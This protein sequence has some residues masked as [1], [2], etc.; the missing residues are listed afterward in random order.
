MRLGLFFLRKTYNQNTRRIWFSAVAVAV[1]VLLMLLFLSAMNGISAKERRSAWQLFMIDSAAQQPIADVTPLYITQDST[2]NG[3]NIW[4]NQ[5][6]ATYSLYASSPSSPNLPGLETPAAGTYYASPQL[7]KLIQQDTTGLLNA[8]LGGV[9]LGAIPDPLLTS[10]EQLLVIRGLSADEMQKANE[11]SRLSSLYSIPKDTQ[12]FSRL[13]WGLII[14]GIIGLLIPV[15]MFISAATRFGSV[16]KN[17]RYAALRLVGATRQQIIGI[18]S[19]ETLFVVL[20][21]VTIGWLLYLTCRPILA[22][23]RLSGSRFFIEDMRVNGEQILFVAAAT[24][25]A[26]IIA[27][28]KAMRSVQNSPLGV[29][30]VLKIDRSPSILSIIPL[31]VGFALL[32]YTVIRFPSHFIDGTQDSILV[33]MLMAAFI[34]ISSGILLS[35]PLLTKTVASLAARIS[36]RPEAI[37]A[38]KRI[39]LYPH[40]SFM[41]V[42]GVI[43]ALFLGSYYFALIS[44]TDKLTAVQINTNSYWLLRDDVLMIQR[45]MSPPN[46][47]ELFSMDELRTKIDTLPNVQSTAILQQEVSSVQ[48]TEYILPCSVAHEY[49]SINCIENGI[50][51]INFNS[52]LQDNQS[53]IITSTGP[54]DPATAAILVKFSDDTDSTLEQI[55]NNIINKGGGF[56]Y[57]DTVVISGKYA[58]FTPM[59]TQ[60][61]EFS[62][63]AYFE[64]IATMLIATASLMVTT[65]AGL[66]E[67][68]RSFFTLHLSGMRINQLK[69]IVMIESLAP[70][71]GSIIL[72]SVLGFVTGAA[73]VKILFP[74][75]T[76]G[77]PTWKY[78]LVVGVCLLFTIT[79]IS[80]LMNRLQKMTSLTENRSE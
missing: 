78:F 24:I 20:I 4:G 10:P 42:S 64:M 27:N 49:T 59:D 23:F 6:I 34:L 71:F 19:A 13:F 57:N 77:L 61:E 40:R 55:R 43:L 70:L 68:K 8:R 30:L 14:I 29:M 45:P 37:I 31:I 36:R 39:A 3:L 44:G 25:I 11:F 63:L 54:M 75:L 79:V 5:T 18:A 17:K 48:P 65:L 51:R 67:R 76:I 7:I 21:G 56:T 2:K 53:N 58:K 15:V 22:G 9:L 16:Q 33:T 60:S 35:G 47:R 28:R 73:F 32:I 80:L 41:A 1:G 66:L 72:A 74:G 38:T 50:T 26:A 52:P 69:K 46:Q 12:L 62:T